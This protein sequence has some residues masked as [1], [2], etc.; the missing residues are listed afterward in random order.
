MQVNDA[1]ETEFRNWAFA[2]L[3]GKGDYPL[4]ELV[5]DGAERTGVSI[6]AIR[7]YLKKMCSP[8][9]GPLERF[10]FAG[11]GPVH[12]GIKPQIKRAVF[13]DRVTPSQAAQGAT[14]E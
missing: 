4:E 14:G 2:L 13:D 5:A 8:L 12:V 3:L 1:A 7:N 9:Y 6:N 10:R 11:K